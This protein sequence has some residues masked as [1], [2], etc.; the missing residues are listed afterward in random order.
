MGMSLIT[1]AEVL[2]ESLK[3]QCPL[4]HFQDLS[5][6][7]N[8]SKQ[9]DNSD[10]LYILKVRISENG[11]DLMVINYTP[12]RSTQHKAVKDKEIFTKAINT[13]QR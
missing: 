10:L 13:T 3:T 4:K 6:S 1:T 7:D 5:I 12:C 8:T 11:K 9:I 2:Q